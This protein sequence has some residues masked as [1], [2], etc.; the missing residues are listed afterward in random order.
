[1]MRLKFATFILTAATHMFA[2]SGAQNAFISDIVDSVTG[3]A[4]RLISPLVKVVSNLYDPNRLVIIMN[5][6]TKSVIAAAAN[7]SN[8]IWT[9]AERVANIR[10]IVYALKQH[11]RRTQNSVM[12]VLTAEGYQFRSNW[13][14]NTIEVKDCPLKLVQQIHGLLAVKEIVYDIIVNQDSTKCAA[15]LA[16]DTASAEWGVTKI[17]APNVWS[18]KNIGQNVVIGNIDTGV[19]SSHESLINNWVGSHGW[20]DPRQR[21]VTP[22]DASGHGTHTMATAVGGKGVGVAPGAKWLACKGCGPRSC[23]LSLLTACAQFMLCPTDTSGNNCDPSKAPHIVSNSWGGGQDPNY[24]QS[25]LDA[26]HAAR[27]IPVFSAGNSGTS[28]CGSIASPSDSSKVFSVG[29]TDKNDNL[30]TFS[31]LGPA[32]NGNIKPD[33]VGP[34]VSIRSAWNND[35]SEYRSISGTSMA[36]PHL[37]GT[38]ALILSAR[39]GLNFDAV[40]TVLINST[41]QTLP[42]AALTCGGTSDTVFPNNQYGYG[43]INAEKVVKAAL[44]I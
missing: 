39:P 40:K 9:E 3:V 14:S 44:A 5:E 36:A 12:R 10:N 26:W 4:P 37:A 17:R 22:F 25:S 16:N 31:S 7:T 23:S 41:D 30:A 13:I 38:I 18:S 27:I 8:A 2:V 24:F 11:A 34:G 20:F 15:D 42:K 33:F 1:M 6:D 21:T 19:R 32:T 35:N 28:G 43:R 29:A